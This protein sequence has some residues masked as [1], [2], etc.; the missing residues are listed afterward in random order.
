MVASEVRTLANR[1]AEAAR[2]IKALIATSVQQVETGSR[3]AGDAGHTMQQVVHAI[4]E[5]AQTM[6]DLK[7]GSEAQNEDLAAIHTALA[8]L[9]NMTQQNA[10]LVEQSSAATESLRI[11]ANDLA[12][13]VSQFL[14]PGTASPASTRDEA[15]AMAYARLRLSAP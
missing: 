15:D 10:A 6:A 1:S 4:R 5:A 7:A 2:Q 13:L 9:D 12:G 14:L 8:Q 11:Q 3:L